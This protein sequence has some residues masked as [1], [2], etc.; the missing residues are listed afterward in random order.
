MKNKPMINLTIE[1]LSEIQRL[2]K[3]AQRVVRAS[4]YAATGGIEPLHSNKLNTAGTAIDIAAIRT[5][6]N[7]SSNAV[8]AAQN[9]IAAI[10]DYIQ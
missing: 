9:V 7:G 5:V 2:L 1:N 4:S 3:N 8:N 6:I 10:N